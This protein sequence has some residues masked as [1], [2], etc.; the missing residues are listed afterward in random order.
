MCLVLLCISVETV[1][2]IFYSLFSDPSVTQG[3]A[4]SS[5]VCP[6]RP[7]TVLS[8][9]LSTTSTI[10]TSRGGNL[11]ESPHCH[12]AGIQSKLEMNLVDESKIMLSAIDRD[13]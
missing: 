9:R 1:A 5:V 10:G 2:F 7:Y 12:H 11:S 13:R 8:D 6:A 4:A 3:S